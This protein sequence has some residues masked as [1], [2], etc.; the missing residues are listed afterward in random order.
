MSAFDPDR[1]S[2]DLNALLTRHLGD[3]E[4]EARFVAA[5]EAVRR[6]DLAVTVA[7]AMRAAAALELRAQDPPMTWA[8]LGDL[9]DVSPQRAEQY[10]RQ[11]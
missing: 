1:L 10:A 9:V 11:A 3:L 5:D 8:A 6:V 7:R 2:D 4:P